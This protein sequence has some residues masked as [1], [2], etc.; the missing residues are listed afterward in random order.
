MTCRLQ[1]YAL[2][3]VDPTSGAASDAANDSNAIVAAKSEATSDLRAVVVRKSES[4][5]C[6]LVTVD[7]DD[8]PC[9]AEL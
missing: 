9:T 5:D 8:A 6:A 3:D 2:D 7:F 1:L 4:A